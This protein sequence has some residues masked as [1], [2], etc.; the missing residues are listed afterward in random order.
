M[1]EA[2][3]LL[4][5]AL[6][7]DPSYSR[8]HLT[9]ASCLADAG[10]MKEARQHAEWVRDTDAKLKPEAEKFIVEVLPRGWFSR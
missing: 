7:S 1:N 3:D 6:R 9:L 5:R 8:A 10:R 2:I 4:N